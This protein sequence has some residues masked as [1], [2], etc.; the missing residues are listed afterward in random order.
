M[1]QASLLTALAVFLQSAGA[2]VCSP[3][4]LHTGC[5]QRFSTAMEAKD[6]LV[7]TAFAATQKPLVET[8]LLILGI[9]FFPLR[10]SI[11]QDCALTPCPP[12]PPHPGVFMNCDVFLVVLNL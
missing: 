3:E 2:D 5:V 6:P 9:L 10:T 7:S 11:P 8:H 4:R 12:P 1:D